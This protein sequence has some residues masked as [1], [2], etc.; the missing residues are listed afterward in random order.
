MSRSR[1]KRN[2]N[3]LN[4]SLFPFL[5]VLICTLGVL[6]VMLVLAVKSA[7]VAK[8]EDQATQ[9][10]ATAE[11]IEEAKQRLALEEFRSES[12]HEV[13]SDVLARLATSR[14]NR[15]YLQQDVS[16]ATRGFRCGQQATSISKKVACQRRHSE[17]S[18]N[19]RFGSASQRGCARRP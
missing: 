18:F 10:Q 9:N 4:V 17:A 8:E 11:K 5:A 3:Q 14:Q 7:V 2:Q 1:K 19:R 12:I 15:S 6:I 16:K 13:R